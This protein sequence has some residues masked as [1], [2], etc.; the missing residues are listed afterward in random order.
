MLWRRVGSSV[1]T[2]LAAAGALL[3]VAALV[4][5]LHRA[6]EYHLLPAMVVPVALLGVTVPVLVER[7]GL[8]G[9]RI[10]PSVAIGACVAAVLVGAAHLLTEQTAGVDV[11][12][13]GRSFPLLPGDVPEAQATL[14]EVDRIARPG[15]RVFVGPMDMRRTN[16]TATY[17]YFLLPQLVPATY[18]QEMEPLTDNLPP[19]HL[20]AD[21]AGADVLVLTTKWDRWNEPNQSTTVYG[22]DLP[23]QAVS[24][25]FCLRARAGTFSVF[26]RC[27]ARG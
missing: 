7:R 17:M 16:Y 1:A 27:D 10:R 19:S 14:D 25:L 22:S 21:V 13:A 24:R 6:D 11:V 5:I 3:S 8:P 2:R 15:Q 9:A 18:Y 4:E 20:A 23:N 12:N 26:T